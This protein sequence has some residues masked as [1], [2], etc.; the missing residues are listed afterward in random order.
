M[1][2]PLDALIPGVK[3]YRVY[4]ESSEDPEVSFRI[5]IHQFVVKIVCPPNANSVV[6]MI[7]RD[8]ARRAEYIPADPQ[9]LNYQNLIFGDD[10]RIL[11]SVR[12]IDGNRVIVGSDYLEEQEALAEASRVYNLRKG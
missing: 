7:S 10:F 6:C 8:N 9:T 2:F 4:V 3:L 1:P 5:H 12:T 11:L